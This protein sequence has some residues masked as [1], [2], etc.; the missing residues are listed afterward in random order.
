MSELQSAPATIA[1]PATVAAPETGAEPETVAAPETARQAQRACPVC[2][3]VTEPLGSIPGKVVGR[4]F[5]LRHC[6]TCRFSF[7][8]NPCTDY[9]L[10][11]NE[12]YYHGR[13]ADPLW[14]YVFELEHPTDTVRRCEWNGI[15]K[16]VKTLFDVKPRTRWLDFGCGSGGLLRQ[17][18]DR[19]HCEAFG[20]DVGSVTAR[21]KERG[22]PILDEHQLDDVGGTIDVVT[23]IEV[24]EH[25]AHPLDVFRRVRDLLRPG[26]LFFYTTGNAQPYRGRLAEWGYV[27]PDIHIS[28][29]E[30]QTLERALRE[31]GLQPQYHGYLP[32][33][34]DIIRFKV[35]KNLGVR[36]YHAWQRLLP[37]G[38]AARLIDRR[39]GITA[40]PVA[41]K[42][43]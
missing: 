42:P 20:Y 34:T 4:E 9:G 38:P 32:G 29:F 28:F 7:V 18:R 16:A 24:I 41:W 27:V 30:P 43:K 26:G 22:M 31:A 40:H 37:W 1:T 39:L 36:R 5:H 3:G 23:A 35:L 15:I 8:A 11:Y 14:D 12:D 25:V 21:A 6:P 10:I 13:G 19:L 2:G 33:Y 17:V